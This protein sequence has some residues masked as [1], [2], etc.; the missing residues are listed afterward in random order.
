[1]AST[2]SRDV[3]DGVEFIYGERGLVTARDIETNIAAS[4]D[5]KAAALAELADALALHEGGG[6]PIEDET[7]F[8]REIGLDP[9]EID[10]AREEHDEPPEFLR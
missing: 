4:G 1:M 10:A 2:S 9:A 8:L 3:P 7:A 6:E 5:T